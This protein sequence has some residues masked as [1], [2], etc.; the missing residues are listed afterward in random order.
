MFLSSQ[1]PTAGEI[2]DVDFDRDALATALD[3]VAA[4]QAEGDI[5]WIQLNFAGAGKVVVSA[6]SHSM[7]IKYEFKAK[8]EGEGILKIS[9]K[10]LAD[11]VKQLPSQRITMKAE[12]P[13]RIT[14]KCG[15][16]SAKM[17]LIQ[18]QTLSEVYVPDIGTCLIGKGEML[19]RWVDTFRDFVSVDDTRYYANGAYIWA[20]T[21]EKTLQLNAVASDALRLS[22]AKLTEGIR[23]ERLDS[24]PVLV[25]KKTLDEMRRVCSQDP[26]REYVL[27]WHKESLFFSLETENYTLISKC[28]SGEYPPYASAIPQKINTELQLE[29]K[30]LMESV[31]RVLLFADKNKTVKLKFDGGMLEV[32]SFTAGLKEG[33]E[34]IE[35]AATVKTPFEVNYNGNLLAGILNA[36]SGTHVSFAWDDMARP[37]KITGEKE[38]GVEVFYLL[39]STRF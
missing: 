29:Q 23:A 20:D 38:R 37:V 36:L 3:A 35:L 19:A 34:L 13:Q 15:R 17:Q 2:I 6:L 5:G 21:E 18:D 9:G 16:S 28:I 33:E 30:A 11:Y 27:R 8:Y 31:K 14:L 25:P 10:Q 22:K 12:L 26:G 4:A 24:G 7:S 1:S 39:V 32:Q